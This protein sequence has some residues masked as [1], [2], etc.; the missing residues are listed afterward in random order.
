MKRVLDSVHGE[1]LIE[2]KYFSQIIDTPEFQ[3]LRHIDQSAIRSVFPCARH[4]RFVHSLGVFHIGSKIAYHLKSKLSPNAIDNKILE[5][6]KIACLLHDIGHAPFSHTFEEYFG[7]KKNLAKILNGLVPEIIKEKE[8]NGPNYHE[9][10]SAILSIKRFKQAIEDLGGDPELVARMITGQKY[11]DQTRSL[12]NC[13]IEL[14]HGD[15]IDADRIDYACRDVWASGYATA[16]FDVNRL[17]NAIILENRKDVWKIYYKSSVINEIESLLKIRDFQNKNVIGHHTV[18]YDQH[19]L[20]KA[21]EK[22]AK[23]IMSTAAHENG[24]QDT[25]S[26]ETEKAAPL[27][28]QSFSIMTDGDLAISK[29]CSL[30]NL[31]DEGKFRYLSDADLL[32]MIKND[33][34]NE[35]ADQWFSRNYAHI[36]LW[37]TKIEFNLYFPFFKDYDLDCVKFQEIFKTIMKN[38]NIREEDYLLYQVKIKGDI[39]LSNVNIK[40]GKDETEISDV[41]YKKD[42]TPDKNFY[43]AYIPKELK[44]Q[45]MDIIKA[46][47]KPLE[48]SVKEFEKEKDTLELE[49]IRKILQNK[50]RIELPEQ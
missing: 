1:I 25:N 7:E 15:I 46:L 43:F 48:E 16:N 20:L 6:Y 21:V 41:I 5:S 50:Y 18:I 36:P 29:I 30:E 22:T 27:T 12:D 24:K 34:D 9:Y 40:I 19:L 11:T 49:E 10:T 17:I 3:R 38:S 23:H 45:R 44:E 14:L 4:D 8:E 47:R 39:D 32:H 13:F 26:K 35:F 42:L 31:T 2:K 33:R 28:E 37:K